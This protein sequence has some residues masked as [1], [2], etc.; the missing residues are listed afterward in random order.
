M[1]DTKKNVFEKI[2]RQ[3]VTCFNT[4]YVQYLKKIYPELDFVPLSKAVK[5]KKNIKAFITIKGKGSFIANVL[6][7]KVWNIKEGVYKLP[8]KIPSSFI[9]EKYGSYTDARFPSEWEDCVKSISALFALFKK[10]SIIDK[11]NFKEYSLYNEA[12]DV[13]LTPYAKDFLSILPIAFP[14]LSPYDFDEV[15]DLLASTLS[16][17]V[18]TD[19]YA[20]DASPYKL[21]TPGGRKRIVIID[22][23]KK[24]KLEL[25]KIF[26]TE[27]SYKKMI[28]DAKM[29]HPGAAFFLLE[30]PLVRQN[31]KNGYLRKFATENGVNVITEQVSSFSILAQ[32]DEVYT[33]SSKIGLDAI[34][35]GKTVHCY[36]LPYYAGW[37]LTKDEIS[38]ERRNISI[39][40]EE[41]FAALCLFFT[42]YM[43]PITGNPSHFQAILHFILLQRPQLFENKRYIA[44]I[45]FN[46]KQKAFF[47]KMYKHADIH[48]YKEQAGIEAAYHNKGMVYTAEE[49]TEQLKKECG[50]IPL[51]YVRPGMF[52]RL[53]NKEKLVSLSLE[54]GPYPSLEK[55]L[56]T[57]EFSER[58]FLRARLFRQF[59]LELSA[60]REHFN[61]E[62]VEEG[63][64][65]IVII[66]NADLAPKVMPV[67]EEVQEGILGNLDKKGRPLHSF[68][69]PLSDDG[70]L[71]EYI[72]NK[73]PDAYIIYC[74]QHNDT[75][76]AQ[77]TLEL[78]DDILPF[79][80]PSDFVPTKV[81][82]FE[83]ETCENHVI[84]LAD[85]NDVECLDNSSLYKDTDPTRWNKKQI[86]ARR[87]LEKAHSMTSADSRFCKLY[88]T[89]THVDG[90]ALEIH[91]YDSHLGIDALAIPLKVFTYGWPYYGG[92]GLTQDAAHYSL[93]PR[94]LSYEQVLA[95]AFIMQPRYFDVE[96]NIFCEP[97][98]APFLF[99]KD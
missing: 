16:H 51:V 72:R 87:F 46:E 24:N 12:D 77:E 15:T 43:H 81:L 36:G 88:D 39:K 9:L 98:N 99:S 19:H 22:Q 80:R 31:K 27:E 91:T 3:K 85:G 10:H 50:N 5:D 82:G 29:Q 71:I 94:K 67:N 89:I 49:P 74:P 86:S 45:N 78:V 2:E 13:N 79:A 90:H 42:R 62:D 60:F 41:L 11:Q 47:S 61:Y 20:P 21:H 34:L 23:A 37:G 53:Y 52:D 1:Q 68:S 73:R 63:K 69:L 95:G 40:K 97:E 96:K 59:F 65:V 70:K 44:C 76:V 83:E 33:V 84:E 6:G 35:L 30:P 14:A 17:K 28:T 58:D 64:D 93:R 4:K 66:G 55:I 75:K 25:K 26:A 32:A 92:W 38:C 57:K 48:F 54:G 7:F 18:S 8:G 56:L